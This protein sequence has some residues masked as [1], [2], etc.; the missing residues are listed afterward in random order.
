M[1]STAAVMTPASTGIEKAVAVEV[2]VATSTVRRAVV[3]KRVCIWF[4]LSSVLFGRRI[5]GAEV[6]QCRGL[7][8][9]NSKGQTYEVITPN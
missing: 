5:A 3:L 6:R 8:I 2:G 4:P 1:K 9:Q 7:T